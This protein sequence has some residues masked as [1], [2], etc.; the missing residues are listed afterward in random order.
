[1]KELE[2]ELIATLTDSLA[3]QHDSG[4]ELR[5]VEQAVEPTSAVEA[6]EQDRRVQVCFA[7][8]PAGEIVV[9]WSQ[10]QVSVLEAI[11]VVGHFTTVDT[12]DLLDFLPKQFPTMQISHKRND[13]E[14]F[15]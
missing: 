2:L 9:L 10:H 8:R 15:V 11:D 7:W 12:P 3:V 14:I 5:P 4:N 13:Q 6:V 1:V